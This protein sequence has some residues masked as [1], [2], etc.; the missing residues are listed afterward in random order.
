MMDILSVDTE[1]TINEYLETM[2]AHGWELVKFNFVDEKHHSIDFVIKNK[3]DKKGMMIGIFSSP[4]YGLGLF[5]V[6]LCTISYRLRDDTYFSVTIEE[7]ISGV[8]AEREVN[9]LE[10][11]IAR[12]IFYDFVTYFLFFIITLIYLVR[13]WAM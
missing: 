12:N 11:H 10:E 2:V 8:A 1:I 6:A 9:A 13:F 5:L 3:L 4:L 7:I